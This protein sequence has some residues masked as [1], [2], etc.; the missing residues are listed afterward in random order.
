MRLIVWKIRYNSCIYVGW[1]DKACTWSAYTLVSQQHI[2]YN[3]KWPV[4]CGIKYFVQPIHTRFTSTSRFPY[5]SC[6]IAYISSLLY[7]CPALP[8]FIWIN[9]LPVCELS[10]CELLNLESVNYTTTVNGKLSNR[11]FYKQ[12]KRILR[13]E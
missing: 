6:C 4:L 11:H 9:Y 12:N 8:S 5:T 1:F 3:Q 2:E 10:A 7:I 13:R